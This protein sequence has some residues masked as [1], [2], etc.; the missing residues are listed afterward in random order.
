VSFAAIGAAPV[1]TFRSRQWSEDEWAAAAERL[2]ARGWI[3]GDGRATDV[4][5]A[6]REQVERTTDQ[7]AAEHWKAIGEEGIDRLAELNAP[8]FTA[9]LASG[10]LPGT[11]TIGIATVPGPRW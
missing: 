8:I 1:E 9:A 11:N 3:D 5:A 7:L 2:R 6:G 4:G 10:L